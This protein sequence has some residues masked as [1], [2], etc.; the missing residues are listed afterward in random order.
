MR[1]YRELTMKFHAKRGDGPWKLESFPV[2]ELREGP[3]WAFL[4]ERVFRCASSNIK[5]YYV[6][7]Y[8]KNTYLQVCQVEDAG[9]YL[10]NIQGYTGHVPDD[11]MAKLTQP[12]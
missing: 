2:L 11:D 5:T 6:R 12:E 3:W 8:T 10:T 7:D 1:L 4:Q 9:M